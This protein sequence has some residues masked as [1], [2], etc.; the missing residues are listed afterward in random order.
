MSRSK[1]TP[2]KRHQFLIYDRL[3]G[4]Y[5]GTSFFIA[6]GYLVIWYLKRTNTFTLGLPGTPTDLLVGALA[7]VGLWFLSSFLPPFAYVQPR[8]DHIRV[9]TPLM[10]VKIPYQEIETTRPIAPAKIYPSRWLRGSRRSTIAA[11]QS[12][13]AIIIDMK[14]YPRPRFIMRIFFDRLFFSPEHMGMVLIVEDWIGLSSQI[15]SKVDAWRMQRTDIRQRFSS[16]TARVLEDPIGKRRS[17]WPFN[18]PGA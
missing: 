16:D 14:S 15:S 6:I 1:R 4:R 11:L 13:T 12:H 8:D 3:V 2:N 17:V 9:Q 5:R 18:S 7:A 10:R